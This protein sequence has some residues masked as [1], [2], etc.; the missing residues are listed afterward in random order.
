MIIG[1]PK[2]VKEGEYRIAMTP[3][4]VKA[5]TGAGH[6]VRVQRGSGELAGFPDADYRRAGAVLVYGASGAWASDMV[7][8][9]KEPLSS[10]FRYFRPNK[11]LFAFLHLA[12]N[13][14]LTLALLKKKMI[15]IGYETVEEKSGQL[16][17]LRCM[18]EIA[19][20][21]AAAGCRSLDG[22]RGIRG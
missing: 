2:E 3:D 19:G 9:V 20:R 5:V 14:P 10:E 6:T 15:A 8:K 12:P 4:G 21:I 13:R 17:I 22:V 11:I 1:V 7:V 16:P 18:S